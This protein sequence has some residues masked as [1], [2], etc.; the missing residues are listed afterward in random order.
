[1]CKETN[2]GDYNCSDTQVDRLV[3]VRVRLVRP[4]PNPNPNHGDYNCS[5]AQVDLKYWAKQGWL[6][7]DARLQVRRAPAGNR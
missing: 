1:M 6:N 3:R 5:D 4:N 7:S 2:H